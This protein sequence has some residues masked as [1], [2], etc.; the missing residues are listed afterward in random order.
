MSSANIQCQLPVN[1]YPYIII[2]GK[3]K[4][5]RHF[6]II[7]LN[8][9]ILCQAEFN[10]QFSTKSKVIFCSACHSRAFVKGEKTIRISTGSATVYI[11][12]PVLF[13]CILQ[14]IFPGC[15]IFL[16][17][18]CRF[19]AVKAPVFYSISFVDHFLFKR[20]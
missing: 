11:F 18:K 17:R 8:L 5:N 7:S 2:S 1:K 9:S 4:S 19:A 14:V 15:R 6:S 12:R 20:K 13:P 10:L 3:L 16:H